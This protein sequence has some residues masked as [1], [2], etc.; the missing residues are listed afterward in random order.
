VAGTLRQTGFV[1]VANPTITSV[2]HENQTVHGH[3]VS[4]DVTLTQ[5]I[6]G[7]GFFFD[8]GAQPIQWNPATQSYN[9]FEDVQLHASVTGTYSLATGGHTYSGSLNYLLSYDLLGFRQLTM[10]GGNSITLSQLNYGVGTSGCDGATLAHILA[11]DGLNMDLTVGGQDGTSH[12]H[13]SYPGSITL[14]LTPAPEPGGIFALGGGLI[15]LVMLKRR[16]AK[17][18]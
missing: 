18:I 1:S 16:F 8:T 3:A 10:N 4:G 11:G 9:V 15:G 7:G 6:A 17:K 12:A 14:S 2:L 5:Q 13:W